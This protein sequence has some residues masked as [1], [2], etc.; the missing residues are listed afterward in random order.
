MTYFSPYGPAVLSEPLISPDERERERE[1]LA[2]VNAEGGYPRAVQLK[3]G[4]VWA[5]ADGQ[6]WRGPCG[7]GAA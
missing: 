6:F 4:V 1:M 3:S 5:G 7:K 2:R